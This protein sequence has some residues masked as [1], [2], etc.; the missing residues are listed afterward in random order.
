MGWQSERVRKWKRIAAGLLIALLVLLVAFIGVSNL[1]Y[2]LPSPADLPCRNC[3]GEART[4]HVNGFDVYF[5]ELGADSGRVPV[6]VLHGGPGHSSQS[7]KQ[8][9]D[10][11]AEKYRVIY[12]DQRGSG[13]SQIRPDAAY[14]T[15][16]KLI[17]ELEAIRRDVIGTEKITVIGHSAGGA[18]A[19][20]Y[21][22][23]HREHVESMVLVSSVPINNGIG[24]PFLWDVF[25]PALFI[26]GAGFPPTDPEAA[27]EWFGELLLSTSLPRLYESEN[28]ALIEDSGYI[29]FATWRE[30]SRSLEGDDFRDELSQLPVRTMVIYGEA[31]TGQTGKESAAALCTLLPDCELVG[32]EQSG[33]WPFLEEPEKFEEEVLT[34]LAG[35]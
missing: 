17:E 5:R 4:V 10:F 13:N 35:R 2:Y 15:V 1:L 14:Y 29:S 19:Q 21:A 18:L 24:M 33:H 16:D 30:V 3:L 23:A 22:L 12:Y 34:F 26:L 7:L 32:F 8:G 11:L 20:R 28:R 9:L 27:N 6:V 25:G 31:D